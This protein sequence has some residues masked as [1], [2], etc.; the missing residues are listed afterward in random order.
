M[1][2]GTSHG[3]FCIGR[4]ATV[5]PSTN[6]AQGAAAFC[7]NCIS[8]SSATGGSKWIAADAT[9]S[10]VAMSSGCSTM[11]FDDLRRGRRDARV[12]RVGKRH[13]ERHEGEQQQRVEAEDQ[14][15]RRVGGGP[16]RREREPRSHVADI[17]VAA[18]QA[19]QWS[20]PPC[21]RAEQP[22]DREGEREHRGRSPSMVATMK[23][24]VGQLLERRLRH[25]AVE[26]AGSAT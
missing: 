6:S 3:I 19:R 10:T 23:R 12:A 25:D 17:A 8:R 1:L 16:E 11:L 13:Q 15:D 22:P 24:R 20:R 5:T 14:R 18:R 2:N 26:Q 21:C 4:S 7:R 9:P